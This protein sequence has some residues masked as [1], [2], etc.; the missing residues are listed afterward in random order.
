MPWFTSVSTAPL[1]FSWS[2]LDS[3]QGGEQG[4][5][6]GSELTRSEVN[7]QVPSRV[8]NVFSCSAIGNCA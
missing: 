8:E 5:E 1:Q 6:Q 4:G 2:D 7:T 3:S